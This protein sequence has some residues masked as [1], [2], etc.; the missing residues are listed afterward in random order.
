M[1][2]AAIKALLAAHVCSRQTVPNFLQL[3]EEGLRGTV[4]FVKLINLKYFLLP[5]D[6]QREVPGAAKT[7]E[8][9]K[10][11][12][13]RLARE[14]LSFRPEDEVH[15][16]IAAINE[17][18]QPRFCRQQVSGVL[19]RRGPLLYDD[20]F[21]EICCPRSDTILLRY[22]LVEYYVSTKKTVVVMIELEFPKADV[23]LDADKCW[24]LASDIELLK[25]IKED[26]EEVKWRKRLQKAEKKTSRASEEEDDR[27]ITETTNSIADDIVSSFSVRVAPGKPDPCST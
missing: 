27:R 8:H 4:H 9:F 16:L 11:H 1:S 12:A 10:F 18:R 15:E 13:H 26:A 22:S 2:L 20:H 5:P 19:G 24:T 7:A 25:R 6:A 14:L 21:H 17:S 3:E 23:G